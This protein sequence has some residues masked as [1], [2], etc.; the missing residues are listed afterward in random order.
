M[1]FTRNNKIYVQNDGVDMG[2]PLGLI[3]ANVFMRELENT[4]VSRLHQYFKKWRRYVDDTSAYVKN[5][6]IDNI[7]TTLS[8]F[9]SNKSFTHEKQINK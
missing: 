3:L 8:L 2:S 9:H 6:S 1:Y 5:K 4:L 7:L